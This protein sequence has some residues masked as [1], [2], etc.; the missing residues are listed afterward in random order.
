M[1]D[2]NRIINVEIT[3]PALSFLY[4]AASTSPTTK[5]QKSG[6]LKTRYKFKSLTGAVF[7]N[8]FS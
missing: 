7:Q 3:A 2:R 8:S 5:V 6:R 1:P 4:Y